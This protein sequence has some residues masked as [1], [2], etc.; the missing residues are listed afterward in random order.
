MVGKRKVAAWRVARVRLLAAEIDKRL[1]AALRRGAGFDTKAGFILTAS[2]LVAGSSAVTAA[3]SATPALATI[4]IAFAL[5][6]VGA[7]IWALWTRTIDVPD[8]RKIVDKWAERPE[9]PEALEKVLLDVGT[10]EVEVREGHNSGRAKV[11]TAGFVMLAIAV[12]ALLVFVVFARQ[13][14]PV[15]DTHGTPS[16]TPA[17]IERR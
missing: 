13:V 9:P 4:P 10:Y 3:A 14:A 8:A 2:G 1:E 11:V 15:G 16:T 7:A 6:G 12:A 17:V 5:L